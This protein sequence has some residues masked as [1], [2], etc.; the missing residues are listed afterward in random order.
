[1]SLTLVRGAVPVM[2]GLRLFLPETWTGDKA[3]LDRA[4]V[5]VEYRSAQRDGVI[6]QACEINR[7]IGRNPA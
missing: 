5:P 1:M 7:A 3:R 6:W 4:G 2:V